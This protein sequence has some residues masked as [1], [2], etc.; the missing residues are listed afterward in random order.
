MLIVLA[1]Y[2]FL[3]F[4]ILNPLVLDFSRINSIMLLHICAITANNTLW[5]INTSVI[6]N[7]LQINF[8]IRFMRGYEIWFNEKDNPDSNKTTPHG[9]SNT[10]VNKYG[11]KNL[12]KI[13]SI[14][15]I[16]N[17]KKITGNYLSVFFEKQLCRIKPCILW[18]RR[19]GT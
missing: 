13:S 6:R 16:K 1:V 12:N 15:G 4:F 9:I 7:I 18:I 19:T 5:V 10:S 8:V 14:V 17:N 3:S 2:L 11:K